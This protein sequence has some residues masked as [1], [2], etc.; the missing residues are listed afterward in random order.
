MIPLLAEWRDVPGY[1]GHYQVSS[2]GWVKSVARAV[3]YVSRS[4]S[5]M[6]RNLPERI[7][8][9]TP[10]NGPH[11]YGRMTVKLSLGG[12]A[13]TKLVH[14]LVALAFIGPRPDGMEVAHIDG[15]PANNRKDNLRYATPRENTADKFRHGTVLRGERVANAKLTEADVRGIR[16]CS[17][18]VTNA[19]KEFGVSIAQVSRIRSGTRWGHVA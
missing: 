13:H 1:E 18:S 3:P 7:M 9:Q 15:N 8:T 6:A 11:A 12:R 5:I 2:L 19:A 10:D 14:Q 16:E 4:G 17:L